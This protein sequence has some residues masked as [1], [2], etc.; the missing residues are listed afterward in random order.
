MNDASATLRW[1]RGL[2]V[3]YFLARNLVAIALAWPAFGAGSTVLAADRD[4]PLAPFMAFGFLVEI[5]LF[6]VAMWIFA[7]LLQR[8]TWARLLLLIV[9]W[10]ALAGAFFGALAGPRLASI[11]G[12]HGQLALEGSGLDWN[13]VMAAGL[14]QNIL[15]VAFW[16]YLLYVLNV[17]RRV[18]A[19]FTPHTPARDK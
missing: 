8:K 19:E 9:G 11:A 2:F 17:N 16:G 13:R 18:R 12:L 6:A 15:A 14:L 4:V 5:V 10:I 1:L 7:Q 3:A